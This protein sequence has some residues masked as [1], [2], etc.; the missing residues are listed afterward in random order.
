MI[1]N[2]IHDPC[3]QVAPMENEVIGDAN[4]MLGRA[5]W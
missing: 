2:G 5:A 3:F 4:P 1:G